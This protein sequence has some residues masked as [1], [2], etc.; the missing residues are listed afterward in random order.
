MNVKP[1]ASEQ[2][3]QNIAAHAVRPY[4]DVSDKTDRI[5]VDKHINFLPAFGLSVISLV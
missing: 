3:H 1:V 4:A 2:I 5:F